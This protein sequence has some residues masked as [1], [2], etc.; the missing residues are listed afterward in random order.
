[1]S[2]GTTK[3]KP[4][5]RTVEEWGEKRKKRYANDGGKGGFRILPR[6]VFDSDAFNELSKSSKLVLILSLDQLD[7]WY[8]KNKGE[9][10]RDSSVGP[11][12]N[13]GCFSLPSNFL[14]ERGI[15]GSDTIAKA[16]R[17]LVAAGFWETVQT[18]TLLQ[19]GIFRWSDK[20][21]TYNQRSVH[22]RKKI[23]TG[24]KAPGYCLYP[25][26]SRYNEARQVADFERE[27][28]GTNTDTEPGAPKPEL[29]L[30]F[31]LELLPE[32]AA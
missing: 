12:R 17:E 28:S 5:P 1:M 11:L 31:Q 25:N 2:N 9:P 10:K 18:G 4:R 23:E 16:R 6:K 21:V 13:D 26:I 3:P 30:P 29:E 22:D 19:S 8:K 15:S 32:L 27:H 7:Y 14:K 24:A 20:W